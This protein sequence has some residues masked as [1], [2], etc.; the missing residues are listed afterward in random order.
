MAIKKG[1]FTFTFLFDDEINSEAE[2]R[3]LDIDDIMH[4]TRDGSMLGAVTQEL[5][6]VQIA[7]EN[8]ADEEVALRGDGS[9]FAD[10]AV[11][12]GDIE[13]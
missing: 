6:I 12:E 11:D 5:T 8:V 3:G 4:E 13:D 1:T 2:V 7:N 9:F 10:R